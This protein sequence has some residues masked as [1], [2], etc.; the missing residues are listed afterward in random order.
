MTWE[1]RVAK[2]GA[3]QGAETYEIREV[4]YNAAGE[5]RFW[6]TDANEPSGD[7]LE[8]LAA[9]LNHMTRALSKPVLDLD[10]SQ[11]RETP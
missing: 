5:I 3:A 4:Y 2:R 9:D 1:Y 6:S 8:E 7:D 11:R 10:E